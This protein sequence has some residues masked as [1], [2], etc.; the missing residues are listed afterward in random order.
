MTTTTV[1][2]M[3]VE[4]RKLLARGWCQGSGAESEGGAAVEPWSPSARRWSAE[5]ALVGSWRTL[6]KPNNGSLDDD[7][8]GKALIALTNVIGD[9]R[10]WNDALGRDQHQVLETFDRLIAKEELLHS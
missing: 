1:E 3:L 6:Y 7:A 2:L 4:A 9:P 10:A 8:L 5:G